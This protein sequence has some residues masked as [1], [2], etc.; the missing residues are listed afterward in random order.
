MLKTLLKTGPFV[1]LRTFA[2]PFCPSVR[3]V[4]HGSATVATAKQKQIG[5]KLAQKSQ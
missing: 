1:A 2:G 3:A 5:A 4:E